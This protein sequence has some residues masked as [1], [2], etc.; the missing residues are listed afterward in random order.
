MNSLIFVKHLMGGVI[1]IENMVIDHLHGLESSV[2]A[3]VCVC[4]RMY[5]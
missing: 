2:C 1:E 3:R 5:M 4:A